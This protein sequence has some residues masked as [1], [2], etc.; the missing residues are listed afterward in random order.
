VTDTLNG[1]NPSTI[2]LSRLELSVRTTNC[3]YNAGLRTIGDV[4]A[5]SEQE[6]M[7]LPNFGRRSLKE[8]RE[9]LGSFNL[10]LREGPV[11]S[12]EQQMQSAL[13]RARAAKHNYETALADIQRVAKLMVEAPITGANE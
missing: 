12:L 7:A 2:P 4:M 9:L 10:A 1:L 8:V 6:L 3:L 5:K 13:I 11:L